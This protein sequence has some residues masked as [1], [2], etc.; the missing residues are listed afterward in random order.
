MSN[1]EGV[2][3]LQEEGSKCSHILGGMPRGIQ[4]IPGTPPLFS[5]SASLLLSCTEVIVA[6]KN[7][8]SLTIQLALWRQN[9]AGNWTFVSSAEE[10][11]SMTTGSRSLF[12]DT[13][14][15]IFLCGPLTADDSFIFSSS[16]G[17]L[18]LWKISTNGIQRQQTLC[19]PRGTNPII[20]MKLIS[21]NT[22]GLITAGP[23]GA[24]A[25]L[26]LYEIVP[27]FRSK[28]C[29][30]IDPKL[31]FIDVISEK[32]IVLASH[33]HGLI[34]LYMMPAGFIFWSLR[35]KKLGG[36][37]MLLAPAAG[38]LSVGLPGGPLFLLKVDTSLIGDEI[39]DLSSLGV[40][41][42]I[43]PQLPQDVMSLALISPLSTHG[44]PDVIPSVLMQLKSGRLFTIPEVERVNEFPTEIFTDETTMG[45]HVA[46]SSR[47][48]AAC[49]QRTVILSA[50]KGPSALLDRLSELPSHTLPSPFN[51]ME[52]VVHGIGMQKSYA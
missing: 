38:G 21:S 34:S 14:F 20:A 12:L 28:S 10:R 2:Q 33:V 4:I 27:E 26:S 48:T 35:L 8:E 9:E 45:H 40:C 39:K 24:S 17:Q 49:R 42:V 13:K 11:S 36:M 22:L 16:D 3:V 29:I 31:D 30:S 46:A 18:S 44:G 6:M 7:T 1:S 23:K 15:R 19:R 25:W 52:N 32:I 43:V 50:G 5:Y 37:R 51:L 41:K 47:R